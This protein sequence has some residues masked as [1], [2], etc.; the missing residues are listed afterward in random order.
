MCK[1]IK[2]FFYD[3]QIKAINKGYNVI[4]T[5]QTKKKRFTFMDFNILE[6]MQVWM[7]RFK[8]ST[9]LEICTIEREIDFCGG[10]K[11]WASVLGLKPP[12]L[13]RVRPRR[14]KCLGKPHSSWTN[15]EM[16]KGISPRGSSSSNLTN[17]SKVK[18]VLTWVTFQEAPAVKIDFRCIG[19]G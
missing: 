8:S 16:F 18:F 12:L 15:R 2:Y 7:Q 17:V 10:A 6:K 14:K 13:A 11:A 3:D 4:F 1:G 5:I 19:K 9:Y